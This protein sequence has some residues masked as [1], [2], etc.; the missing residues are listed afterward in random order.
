MDE[1]EYGT[2]DRSYHVGRKTR[3]SLVYRLN[4]RTSEVIASV[5]RHYT[6]NPGNIIDLGTADGLMLGKLKDAFPCAECLGVEYSLE[7]VQCNTDQ[8]ITVVQGDVNALPVGDSS[9]DIAVAAAILE[10]LRDPATTLSEAKR[11]L[12]PGGLLVLTTPDP[13]WERVATIVGHLRDEA[14]F[15]VMKLKTLVQLLRRV[16]YEILEQRK[17]MLSPIGLPWEKSLE[18]VL[19]RAGLQC[20]L[21]N[22]LVVCRKPQ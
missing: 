2:L 7:L 12:R 11:V 3:R 19:T 8:R 18:S 1:R 15:S 22:Q 17:F 5:R 9:Q 4:R 10:H 20:F 13:F 14:H 6:G 21:A 16:G